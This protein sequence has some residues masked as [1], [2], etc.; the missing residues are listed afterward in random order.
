MPD[1]L[2]IEIL[3]KTATNLI[4]PLHHSRSIDIS[5][6]LDGFWP[7]ERLQKPS[8]EDIIVLRAETQNR[9]SLNPYFISGFSII[10]FVFV[11]PWICIFHCLL[12]YFSS[13]AEDIR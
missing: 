10:V 4:A 9:G 2:Y 6:G 12:L 5:R 11:W 8:S 13:A 3:P 7:I 1:Q